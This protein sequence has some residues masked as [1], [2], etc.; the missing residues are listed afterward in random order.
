[1]MNFTKRP[2]GPRPLQIES[3]LEQG[4]SHINEDA[5]HVETDLFGVFDGATSLSAKRF[6]SPQNSLDTLT[7]GAIASST[8]C[9]TFSC[10]GDTLERLALSA[11]LAI[12]QQ[13]VTHGIDLTDRASLWSTSA[14]VA[15]FHAGDDNGP[16]ALEWIQTGDAFIL[17]LYDD[18]RFKVLGD[19]HDHDFDTLSMWKDLNGKRKTSNLVI[20]EAL[21]DKIRTVRMGMNRHYGVLN[22]ET[23]AKSFLMSGVERLDDVTDIL[24]FTDGLAIPSPIPTKRKS[25]RS[26][27]DAYRSRGL[28]QLVKYIRRLEKSD[29]NCIRYPRFKCHDD[30]AAIAIQ[31]R[32]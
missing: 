9:K 15:R 25:F 27:V 10:N 32:N 13:M 4:S 24:L 18:G 6:P 11:N 26:L 12:R 2:S 29:P 3:I 16:D 28:K 7:G 31:L 20:G 23:E 5:L 8:A 19:P 21:K 30:M 22:G 17:L 1:M 14:A